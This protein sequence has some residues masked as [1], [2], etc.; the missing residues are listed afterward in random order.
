MI[1]HFESRLSNTKTQNEAIWIKI[2][3]LREVLSTQIANY[4]PP[5]PKTYSPQ[6]IRTW[7]KLS[8][9]TMEIIQRLAPVWGAFAQEK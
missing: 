9:S 6:A 5:P 4:A 1:D 8:E 7:K 3:P 2:E